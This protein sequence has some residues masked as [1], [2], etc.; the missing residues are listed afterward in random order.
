MAAPIE[1]RGD[2]VADSRRFDL[3]ETMAFDPLSGIDELGRHLG[4]MRDSAE[5]LGFPFNHHEARNELQAATF[6]AGPSLVRLALSPSGA[7]A[8][9]V[10]D[11]AAPPEE[12]V[13]VAVRPLPLAADDPRLRHATSDSSLD[14]ARA[15]VGTFE[16]LFSDSA[17]FLLRGSASNLFVERE[18]KLLTPPLSRGLMPGVLR[19]KL[20]EEGRAEEADLVEADLVHGFLIGSILLGLVRARLVSVDSA[21]GA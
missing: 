15:S 13:S 14:R 12:P 3:I 17:G 2:R 8:I 4:R 11:R 16:V 10:R 19:G 1:E 6:R 18:G 21:A 20:I 7:M 5:M 9:E